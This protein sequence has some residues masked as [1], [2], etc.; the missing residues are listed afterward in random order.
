MCVPACVCAERRSSSKKGIHGNQCAGYGDKAR[1]GYS[2]LIKDPFSH[3][4]SSSILP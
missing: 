1:G 4:F 2:N 3:C